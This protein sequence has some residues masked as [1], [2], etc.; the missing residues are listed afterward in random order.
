MSSENS[1]AILAVSFGTSHN[2]TRKKTIDRI[3]EEIRRSYPAYP[4]YQAWTSK[5]IRKK[6]WE[7]DHRKIFDICEA[8]EQMRKDGVREVIVQPTHMLNGIE[9]DRMMADVAAYQDEFEKIAIGD[10]LLTTTEDCEKVIRAAV[11]EIH[12]AEDEMLVFMG[13]GTP[14][15]SNFVYPALNYMLKDMGCDN[16]LVATVEAYPSLDNVVKEIRR[17][18]KKKVLLAPFMVVAGDHVNHDLA[19]DGEDSWKSILER[20]GY[21]VSCILRGLGEFAK[22]RG[23][24]LEHIEAVMSGADPC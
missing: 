22:V 12:P 3:E 16:V 7:R 8:M 14:H 21:E 20:E 2:D 19:G 1:R 5:M 11:E 9:N 23:L 6:L 10:P 18:G 13:H 15:Y 4:L 17:S 24:Y